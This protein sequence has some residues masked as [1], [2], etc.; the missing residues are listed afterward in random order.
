MYCKRFMNVFLIIEENCCVTYLKERLSLFLLEEGKKIT[1]FSR[2]E[3][4]EI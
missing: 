4:T 3:E 1:C 2:G